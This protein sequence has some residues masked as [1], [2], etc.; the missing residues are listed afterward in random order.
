LPVTWCAVRKSAAILFVATAFLFTSTST[1]IHYRPLVDPDPL[2]EAQA[3]PPRLRASCLSYGII[4]ARNRYPPCG[5]NF[6][7]WP[8]RAISHARTGH[9]GKILTI[10]EEK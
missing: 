1:T 8:H 9:S 5:R 3:S 10:V 4:R 2:N 6:G 7:S